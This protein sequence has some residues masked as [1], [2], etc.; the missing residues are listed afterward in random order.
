MKLT[1]QT[2][3]LYLAAVG[4]VHA[5]N[6]NLINATPK[7]GQTIVQYQF[8]NK[9]KQPE[10]IIATTVLPSRISIPENA[11]GVRVLT[12]QNHSLPNREEM[13]GGGFSFPAKG[14]YWTDDSGRAPQIAFSVTD[15]LIS[16]K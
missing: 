10:G 14:C 8:L 2:V 3:G 16:C 7:S 1:T 6:I 5:A 13:P 12:L 11:S 4:I 9:D 15:H